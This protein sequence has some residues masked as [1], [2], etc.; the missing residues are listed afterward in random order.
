MLDIRFRI[1][2][3]QTNTRCDFQY[4]DLPRQLYPVYLRFG[5]LSKCDT[6]DWSF[7]RTIIIRPRHTE[8]YLYA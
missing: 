7:I 3:T 8:C 4:Y 5:I 6:D 2:F 1:K